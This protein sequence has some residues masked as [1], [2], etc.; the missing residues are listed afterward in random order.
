MRRL[1]LAL[2]FALTAAPALAGMIDDGLPPARYDI[3]GATEA[4]ALLNYSDAFGNDG[5]PIAGVPFGM[6]QITCDQINRQR[7]HEAY[8]AAE[9]GTVLTGCLIRNNDMSNPVII[10]SIVPDRP[11]FTARIIRHEAGHLLGWPADH[12]R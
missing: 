8:A 10:Y 11:E 6:A 3:G 4:E 9:A 12:P 2:A 1:L 5:A 7:Y